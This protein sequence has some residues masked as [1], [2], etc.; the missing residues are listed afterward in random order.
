[1]ETL[2]DPSLVGLDE[3]DY[4]TLESNELIGILSLYGMPAPADFIAEIFNDV[5]LKELEV[6]LKR[7][8]INLKGRLGTLQMRGNQLVQISVARDIVEQLQKFDT[9]D[10]GTLFNLFGRCLMSDNV[11]EGATSVLVTQHLAMTANEFALK[12]L[13]ID[14]ETGIQRTVA[15]VAADSSIYV[16][17]HGGEGNVLRNASRVNS[18]AANLEITIA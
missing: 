1:M 13:E 11:I 5:F 2:Q 15:I 4:T 16:G 12:A 9:D 3:D 17:N 8:L 6:W 10:K 14:G 7:R 18:Q